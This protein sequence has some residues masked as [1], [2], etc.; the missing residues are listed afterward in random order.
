MGAE[1]G[2][3]SGDGFSEWATVLWALT[4]HIGDAAGAGA[5]EADGNG[6]W[7]SYSSGTSS[8]VTL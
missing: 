5:A 3:V 2:T 4:L 1:K 7:M 8:T 6:C